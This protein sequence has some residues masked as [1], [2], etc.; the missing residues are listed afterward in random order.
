MTI[1]QEQ[2]A[3]SG[4]ETSETWSA[5]IDISRTPSPGIPTKRMRMAWEDIGQDYD[6]TNMIR[7]DFFDSLLRAERGAQQLGYVYDATTFMGRSFSPGSSS[8]QMV[9]NVPA[10]DRT[11]QE[12]TAIEWKHRKRKMQTG[13]IPCL[14]V[15]ENGDLIKQS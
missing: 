1:P 13:C 2:D 10:R 3:V 11:L 6:E 7:D 4:G 9:R 14:Y 5:E 12:L 8:K 15:R